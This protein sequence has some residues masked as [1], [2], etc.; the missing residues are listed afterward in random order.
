MNSIE[1]RDNLIQ[2]MQ[3]AL[4]F[5]ADQNNYTPKTKND[6]GD[7]YLTMVEVDGGSQ[8]Q[9]A[10]DQAKQLIEQ[11]QKIQD[12]YDKLIM[13]TENFELTGETNPIELI[14]V[15]TETHKDNENPIV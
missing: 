11:N 1:E 8:A 9:F 4:K 5:Y 10:I 3:E 7:R 14:R 15:F 6:L 12:D 13:E 2:L